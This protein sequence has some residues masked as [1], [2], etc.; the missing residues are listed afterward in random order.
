VRQASTISEFLASPNGSYFRGRRHVMFVHSPS[1]IGF[2][3]WG[4]PD[5]EDVRELLRL[6]EVGLK[7]GGTPHRFLADVRSLELV[8]PATFGLF[9]EYTRKHREVLG[10]NILRQAQLRPDGLVGAVIS[11]FAHLALLPYPEKV[12]GDVEQALAWLQVDKAEGVELLA[13][14]GAIRDAAFDGV[15][16]IVRLRQELESSGGREL[17]EIARRLGLSKRGLQRA[18]R[19]AGTSY[20]AELKAFQIRRAQELLRRDERNLDWIAAEVGFSS[21]Q[22]FATAYRRATGDTPSG[23]RTRH[24]SAG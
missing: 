4:R 12:F 22:T 23:W 17:G 24:R 15:P 2:V 10:R 8:E 19:E 11:G 5:V 20:R 9:I 14:L 1:L 21:M 16:S 18:L 6:C 3:T 13:E 7:P